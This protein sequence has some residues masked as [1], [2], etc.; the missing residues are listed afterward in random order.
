[1]IEA[2]KWSLESVLEEQGKQCAAPEEEEE[3]ST[4]PSSLRKR[5]T[6]A[7]EA[8]WIDDVPAS[9]SPA[10]YRTHTLLSREDIHTN[11]EHNAGWIH[12]LPNGSDAQRWGS[13]PSGSP[14]IYPPKSNPA[15]NPFCNPSNRIPRPRHSTSLYPTV[16]SAWRREC[17]AERL[18]TS[19]SMRPDSTFRDRELQTSRMISMAVSSLGLRKRCGQ[20]P[21]R[22]HPAAACGLVF[23]A[24]PAC[25]SS[26]IPFC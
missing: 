18:T 12:T 2:G 11:P 21:W 16:L 24:A 6:P 3:D 26:R 23:L 5:K 9:L 14:A 20:F 7:V 4:N 15:S 13:Y 22:F 19:T 10:E 1:M 17:F 25:L 8:A